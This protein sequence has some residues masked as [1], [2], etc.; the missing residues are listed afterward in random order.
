MTRPK[1]QVALD[2]LEF[3][4]A[5][6]I[7]REAVA[8]GADWI[9]V[10]TPLI[11][12]E[13]MAA[14]RELREAFPDHEIVADMKIADTGTVEVEMAAKAGA[15]I[16]CVLADADDTVIAESVRAA[17]L[18]GVR[19]MADLI[20]VADPV[21]RAQE[22][23]ALG[24]DIV[25]A[26]VGID[27][28][29]IGK[30]S[31]DLLR[32]I[33]GEVSI[34]L[35][36]AGGLDASTA[37]QAVAAGADIVIVGGWIVKARDVEG[38]ART[39]RAALDD[40]TLVQPEKKSLDEEIRALLMTVSAPNVTD[41]MHRKGAMNGLVPLTGGVKAVGPAVTVQT[42]GGDWA[43]PV[44]AI[45]L[46]RPGDVLVI[47][48]DGRT[49]IAPWGEL[50]THSAKNQGISGVVIDGA[51]RDVDDIRAM[52]Y[53]LFARACVP[54]AGEAKGFGEINA[55]IACCGQ[56][57]R[58][59]D[60]IIADESGV[61]VIPKERTYEIARRALEVKKMEDRVREEIERGSTLAQVQELYKW[62]KR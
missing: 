25:N 6:Q 23:E 37:A 7:A 45:D 15:S 49:E 36:V 28:Q 39:I 55:E 11:K 29:M 56:Q 33:V 52:Q 51:V 46:C 22:L 30:S 62:E 59:G 50:A 26:H 12:S 20:N 57:V 61:V 2:I 13:G 3:H 32:S 18:Y 4:R 31:V 54:N 17:R 10:G 27:Q 34:P 35:A 24:V 48:N 40:P 42:F 58:P 47:N 16:V 41:A 44:E 8:G 9:E 5:A 19:I 1:L 60:W 43:K 14:V 21:R 53:P 38:S